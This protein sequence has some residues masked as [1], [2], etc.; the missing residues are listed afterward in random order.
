MKP[1]ETLI[2]EIGTWDD[3]TLN[4]PIEDLAKKY[5]HLGSIEGC[6]QVHH[7]EQ[8]GFPLLV[9]EVCDDIFPDTYD[10]INRGWCIIQLVA[11]HETEFMKKRKTDF[12]EIRMRVRAKE[13]EEEKVRHAKWKKEQ[14]ENERKEKEEMEKKKK[15]KKCPK[16]TIM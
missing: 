14:E 5:M 9:T 4:L 12:E 13:A 6:L 10:T 1:N 16:C 2:F 8:W 7:S 11:E 3:E 15:N